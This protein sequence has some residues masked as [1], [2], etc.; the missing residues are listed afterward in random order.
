MRLPIPKPGRSDVVAGLTVAARKLSK[1]PVLGVLLGFLAGTAEE[2][3]AERAKLQAA[4]EDEP[5]CE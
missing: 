2:W 3:H 1:V 4:E 5:Q